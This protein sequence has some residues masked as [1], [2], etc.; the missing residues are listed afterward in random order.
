MTYYNKKETI[1]IYEKLKKNDN[2]LFQE[3]IS[4]AGNIATRIK[5][6]DSNAKFI[7]FRK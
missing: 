6:N 5:A 7:P 2:L 4:I 1:R 3:D